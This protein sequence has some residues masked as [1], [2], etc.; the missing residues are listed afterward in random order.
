MKIRTSENLIDIFN[1]DL[2]WRKKE[3]SALKALIDY[4]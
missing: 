1:K 3:I 2:I 4:R